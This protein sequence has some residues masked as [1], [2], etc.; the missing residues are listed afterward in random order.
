MVTTKLGYTKGS[1]LCILGSF[2][3][4]KVQNGDMFWVA[5]TSDNFL[6]C[7]KFLIFILGRTVDAG[8]EPTHEEKMRVSPPPLGLKRLVPNYYFAILELW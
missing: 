2:L 3:K 8:P 7:L 5:N 1:F 4:A 6:G